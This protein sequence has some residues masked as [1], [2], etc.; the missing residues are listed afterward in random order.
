MVSNGARLPAFS[1]SI[2]LRQGDPLSPYL[3]VLCMEK[4]GILI[5]EKVMDG[6]WM[7]V[8]ISRHGLAISHLFFAVD[9]LLFVKAKASQVRLMISVLDEFS[10]ASGLKVNLQKSSGFVF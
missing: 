8:K 5:N 10:L 7:L 4:L 2:G 3:F 9:C 1:P 6:E